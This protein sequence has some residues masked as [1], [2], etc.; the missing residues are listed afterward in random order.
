M[1]RRKENDRRK[2]GERLRIERERLGFTQDELASK[3]G[4]T[5]RTQVNYES[6][7][8]VPDADYLMAIA[9]NGLNV[10][11]LL[12]GES[13][14]LE[15]DAL[16]KVLSELGEKLG[17]NGSFL[18]EVV[19]ERLRDEISR[20]RGE[21]VEGR[22][23]NRPIDDLHFFKIF[24][25]SLEADTAL[26]SFLIERLEVLLKKMQRDL[27]PNKK[28]LLLVMLYRLADATGKIDDKM[29]EEAVNLAL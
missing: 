24:K 20:A 26:L 10:R 16:E 15:R 19:M 17:M 3:A 25:K 8:R 6:G 11:Y 13:P 4:I 2:F 29:I 1:S 14:N 12:T 23:T 5:R 9:E 28:A 22:P 21:A 27:S 7:K 18:F